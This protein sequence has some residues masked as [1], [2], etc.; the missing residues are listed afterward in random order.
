MD[1]TSNTLSCNGRVIYG[2]TDR[3]FREGKCDKE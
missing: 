2:Q 3:E 1:D